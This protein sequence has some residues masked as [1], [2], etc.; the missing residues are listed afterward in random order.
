[1]KKIEA[2]RKPKKS[3]LRNS[4]PKKIDFFLAGRCARSE[5]GRLESSNTFEV[6]YEKATDPIQRSRGHVIFYTI[7]VALISVALVL[8]ISLMTSL[9]CD[10]GFAFAPIP[11]RT[12]MPHHNF[13]QFCFDFLNHKEA[14]D[15]TCVHSNDGAA[16]SSSYSS[17][18]SSAPAVSLARYFFSEIDNPLGTGSSNAAALVRHGQFQGERTCFDTNKII[19]TKIENKLSVKKN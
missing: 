11:E 19:A 16:E 17:S 2:S 6:V 13:M 18:S 7:V 8:G 14:V 3:P 1:M 5:Q 15:I 4:S 10:E 9:L 12:P